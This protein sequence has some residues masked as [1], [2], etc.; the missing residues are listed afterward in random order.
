MSTTIR[1]SRRTKDLLTRVLI[2]LENELGR[3]LDYDDVIRILIEKSKVKKPELLLKLKEMGISE[4]IA[5]EARKLLEKE[6]E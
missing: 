2:E 4:E 1:V 5:R 6:K 3:R